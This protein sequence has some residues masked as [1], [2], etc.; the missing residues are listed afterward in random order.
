MPTRSITIDGV[1]LLV[2]VDAETLPGAALAE[3]GAAA[4]RAVERGAVA[5]KV[6]DAGQDLR[7]VL[8]AI[9]KPI[10]DAFQSSNPEEWSIELSVGFK[11]EAGI[12]CITKGEANGAI[13]VTA[14]WKRQI[15]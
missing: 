14:K 4:G 5:D 13:K 2:E 3:R 15:A 6:R 7:N 10:H 12:P 8:A 1:E 11:G 9:A